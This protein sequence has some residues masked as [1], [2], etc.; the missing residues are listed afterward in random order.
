M[1][2]YTTRQVVDYLLSACDC[3][4]NTVEQRL[5]EAFNKFPSITIADLMRAA[6]QADVMHVRVR[7]RHRAG[8]VGVR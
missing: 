7:G 1:T 2:N 5:K 8:R 3:P 4:G 6:E